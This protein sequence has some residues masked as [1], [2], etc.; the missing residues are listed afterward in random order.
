MGAKGLDAG[1]PPFVGNTSERTAVDSLATL[2]DATSSAGGLRGIVIDMQGQPV[3][4]AV[5]VILDPNASPG[6]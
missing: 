5:V 6:Y 1:M 4:N 3:A 2:P